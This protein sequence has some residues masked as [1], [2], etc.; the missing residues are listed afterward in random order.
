MRKFKFVLY[1]FMYEQLFFDK[2]IFFDIVCIF[3]KN[4]DYKF[5]SLF[6]LVISFS[7]LLII[8]QQNR[9]SNV[10]MKS[11]TIIEI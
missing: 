5:L 6:A 11:I 3:D 7:V 2:V 10:F 4:T 8:E 1:F 9:F